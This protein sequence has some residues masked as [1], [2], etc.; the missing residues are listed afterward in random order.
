MLPNVREK[1]V[2]LGELIETRDSGQSHFLLITAL[3]SSAYQKPPWH[4]T[5]RPTP[6]SFFFF[7]FTLQI[8]LKVDL[9]LFLM[10]LPQMGPQ[11]SVS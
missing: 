4:V 3:D 9:I 7:M 5:Q 8:Y 10:H 6:Y 1:L 11:C 2:N